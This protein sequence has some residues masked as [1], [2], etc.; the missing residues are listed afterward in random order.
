M[1]GTEWELIISELLLCFMIISFPFFSES[2][3]VILYITQRGVVILYTTQRGDC[4][5]IHHTD[6]G[7]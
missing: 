3:P 4:N 1:P 6:G 5:T 2:E 7:L